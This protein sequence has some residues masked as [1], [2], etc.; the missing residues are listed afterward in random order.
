VSE[1]IIELFS[2]E[3]LEL[4]ICGSKTLDFKELESATKYVDGY[5]EESPIVTW[6]WEIIHEDMN[7]D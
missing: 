7:D 5:T 6:L 3:E 1:D 2:P 4:L